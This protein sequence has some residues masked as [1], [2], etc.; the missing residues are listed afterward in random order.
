MAII[1]LATALKKKKRLAGE[2]CALRSELE[3]NNS[4]NA[5]AI[6]KFD[7]S[8]KHEKYIN[9]ISKLVSLKAAIAT[10]NTP[11]HGKI[12]MLAELKTLITFYQTLNTTE[13]IIEGPDFSLAGSGQTQTDFR[14]SMN[15]AETRKQIDS[16]QERINNLQDELDSF[17][18]NQTIEWTD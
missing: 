2:V 6:V 13:G 9:A 12:A 11:I 16:I 4:R 3:G 8:L 18:A 5:K 15:Y 1:T 10:A 17:N 14:V 7:W